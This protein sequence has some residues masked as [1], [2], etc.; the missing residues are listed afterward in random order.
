MVRIGV[1]DANKEEAERCLRE[2]FPDSHDIYEICNAWQSSY[3]S[4]SPMESGIDFHQTP[5]EL[6]PG[7]TIIGESGG[8]LF[9]GAISSELG[10]TVAHGTEKNDELLSSYGYEIGKCLTSYNEL[11]TQN[12]EIITADLALL[13][14][15]RKNVRLNNT[16]EHDRQL[17]NIKIYRNPNPHVLV[18]PVTTVLI[19]QKNTKFTKGKIHGVH[20]KDIRS[21]VSQ[22]HLH[23]V[24]TITCEER[25]EK[26]TEE[27]DS[28]ALVMLYPKDNDNVLYVYG[29]VIGVYIPDERDPSRTYTVASQLPDVMRELRTNPTYWTEFRCLLGLH[30]DDQIGED[31]DFIQTVIDGDVAKHRPLTH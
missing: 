2:K 9:S 3:S 20:H 1:D 26:V 18:P 5:V 19:L 11:T 21:R 17:Y 12:N 23:K 31:I 10:L 22:L 24:M 16:V 15:Y 6:S 28:G 14:L 30:D 4:T 27:G 7:T 13:K 25:Q 29:I 8:I